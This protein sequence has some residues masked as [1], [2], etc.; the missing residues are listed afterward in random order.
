MMRAH[1]E[2]LR[3][4]GMGS[5]K[6]LLQK[7]S[8]DPAMIWWLDQ[9]TNHAGAVN[10]NYGRELL[11]LFSMGRG[12]IL[13]MTCV[14]CESFYRWTHDQSIPGIQTDGG[15]SVLSFVMRIMITMRRRFLAD[16]V[17]WMETILLR[18]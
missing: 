11:E 4:H 3:D 16:Q 12:T 18:R 8:R 2:M 9:Q 7:L 15:I 6:T 17:I 5:F 1:L 14:C 10:E 13:K